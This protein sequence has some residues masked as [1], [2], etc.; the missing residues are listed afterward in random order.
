ML[1]DYVEGLVILYAFTGPPS[2]LNMRCKYCIL[3][4]PYC[5]LTASILVNSF[6]IVYNGS[7]RW[8]SGAYC[9]RYPELS[10][11]AVVWLLC[12]VTIDMFISG[13]FLT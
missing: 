2:T 8:S 1:T 5:F 4:R 13:Y 9:R 11:A 6:C 7:G 10:A 3:F 12:T